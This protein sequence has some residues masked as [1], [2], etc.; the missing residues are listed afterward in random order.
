M[1]SLRSRV[2]LFHTLLYKLTSCPDC[3]AGP[4]DHGVYYIDDGMPALMTTTYQLQGNEAYGFNMLRKMDT[5][6]PNIKR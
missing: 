2:A 1:V 4:M 5:N 6:K 3:T